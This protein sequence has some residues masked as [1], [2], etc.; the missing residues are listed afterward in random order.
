MDHGG[1]GK[2]CVATR[3][4]PGVSRI[5]LGGNQKGTRVL[6]GSGVVGVDAIGILLLLLV[7]VRFVFGIPARGGIGIWFGG[8][9]ILPRSREGEDTRRILA[10]SFDIAL[11]EVALC[12]VLFLISKQAL[13]ALAAV[14]ADGLVIVDDASRFFRFRQEES[15]SCR[16]S[17]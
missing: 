14:D 12:A 17:K 2:L 11:D 1:S 6:R 3:A 7:S 10:D 4:L 13:L 9:R 8:R 16:R 5:E 15:R